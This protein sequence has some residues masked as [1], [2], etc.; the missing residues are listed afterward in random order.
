M[1][2][3]EPSRRKHLDPLV[4]QLARA[5]TSKGEV[6][7]VFT[8][9][10]CSLLTTPSTYG[11]I[12]S[13]RAIFMDAYDE[14]TRKVMWKYEDQKEQENGEVHQLGKGVTDDRQVA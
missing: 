7:Y 3:I 11:H 6:N 1:P 4:A 5:L 14:F 8:R 2:Y 10:V 13:A 9:I 12:S